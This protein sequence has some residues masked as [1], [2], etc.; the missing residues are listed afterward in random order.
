MNIISPGSAERFRI[1][2][3]T[4]ETVPSTVPIKFSEIRADASQRNDNLCGQSFVTKLQGLFDA[5][6]R[7]RRSREKVAYRSADIEDKRPR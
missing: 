5:L 6:A 7:D 3:R 2:K 4:P 1:F